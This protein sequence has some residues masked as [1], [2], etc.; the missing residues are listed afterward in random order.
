MEREREGL[1]NC[2]GNN[3]ESTG[4]PCTVRVALAAAL[5]FPAVP[6]VLAGGEEGAEGSNVTPSTLC[7]QIRIRPPQSVILLLAEIGENDITRFDARSPANDVGEKNKR[8]CHVRKNRG[9]CGSQN[10]MRR[11]SQAG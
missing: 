3:G 2:E 5:L 10:G 1:A 8:A 4:V 7:H 6:G 11:M 9:V